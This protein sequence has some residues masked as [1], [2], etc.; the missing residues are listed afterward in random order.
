MMTDKYLE[1]SDKG[2]FFRKYPDVLTAKSSR[3]LR[4]LSFHPD[5]AFPLYWWTTWRLVLQGTKEE[6]ETP[7]EAPRHGTGFHL[8]TNTH[9]QLFTAG[10]QQREPFQTSP[11]TH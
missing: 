7:A 1:L 6:R 11:L 2:R 10:V 5:S 8:S 4:L 3:I 9:T